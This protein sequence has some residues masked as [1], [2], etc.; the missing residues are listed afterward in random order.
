MRS[1]EKID[2]R[3]GPSEAYSDVSPPLACQEARF[4]QG[5]A[6][7]KV[8][9]NGDPDEIAQVL[10]GALEVWRATPQTSVLYPPRAFCVHQ[11]VPHHLPGT[12]VPSESPLATEPTVIVRQLQEMGIA[13]WYYAPD[14]NWVVENPVDLLSLATRHLNSRW[15]RE[16]FLMMTKLGWSVG[17][18]REGPEHQ[19]REVIRR[20]EEFLKEYPES[21]TSDSVRLEVAEAYAT[22]WTLSVS[23]PDPP[24]LSP[25][26]YKSGGEDARENAIQ[27]YQ[28]YL[29]RQKTPKQYVENNLK[30]LREKRPLKR[31]DYYCSD[32]ED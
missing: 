25:D 11:L 5:E 2:L 24:Y 28:Q 10:R 32:Y 12:D 29:S 27:L 16:A 7:A 8:I 14:R 13:Y 31:F 22:W 23:K 20:G 21:E 15:G 26:R 6:I 3:D 4:P 1:V 17:E 30:A 19:F 18:C 9:Q